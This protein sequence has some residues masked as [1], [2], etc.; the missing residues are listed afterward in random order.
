[1]TGVLT[2]HLARASASILAA[3]GVAL[4]FASD[5]I[6]PRVVPG[7]PVAGAWLGQLVGAGWLAVAALDWLGQ[8]ALLGGIYGRPQVMANL[9]LHFVGATSLLRVALRGDAPAALWVWL[10]VSSVLA[11]VYGWLLMRGPL[12]RD[13]QAQRGG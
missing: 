10:V 1:M 4:L 5:A 11:A 2:R 13:L 12:E 7:F 8:S 3:G 9:V 6:L